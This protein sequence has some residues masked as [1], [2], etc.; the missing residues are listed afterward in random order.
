MEGEE[1]EGLRMECGSDI[2]ADGTCKGRSAMIMACVGLPEKGGESLND[3]E[4]LSALVTHGWHDNTS[5]TDSTC[6]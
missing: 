2:L 4:R 6:M 5:F 3:V 1:E